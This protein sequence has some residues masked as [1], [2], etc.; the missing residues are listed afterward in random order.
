MRLYEAFRLNEH[1]ARTAAWVEH[2]TLERLDHRDQQSYDAA[3]RIE[4]PAALALGDGELA[5]EIFIDSPKHVLPAMLIPERQIGE[6]LDH[7]AKP[8]LVD[9]RSRVSSWSG[10]P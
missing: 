5:E 7:L 10:H 9:F 1:A 6:E 2:A 8:G 3:G 4:L